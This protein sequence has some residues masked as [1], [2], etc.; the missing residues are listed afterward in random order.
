MEVYAFGLDD[1]GRATIGT[2]LNVP[3]EYTVLGSKE[4]W[5]NPQNYKYNS[6]TQQWESVLESPKITKTKKKKKLE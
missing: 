3:P 5:E 6:E 2:M 4:I 1:N